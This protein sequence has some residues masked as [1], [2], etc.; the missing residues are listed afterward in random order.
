MKLLKVRAK[1][2][3]E[4]SINL[5]HIRS[6][7]PSYTGDRICND[8]KHTTIFWIDGG[9]TEIGESFNSLMAL[10]NPYVFMKPQ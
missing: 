1:D 4:L 2:G 7:S 10:L 9:N 3:S 8:I 6:F 5:E